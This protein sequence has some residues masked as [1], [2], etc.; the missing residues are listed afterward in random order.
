MTQPATREISLSTKCHHPNPPSR[1][2][3][4]VL[5]ATTDAKTSATAAATNGMDAED[6]ANLPFN[7]DDANHKKSDQPE[8]VPSR[9]SL[10]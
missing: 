2:L 3:T 6:E 9:C 10:I 8:P 7:D 5:Q 4:I 1:T